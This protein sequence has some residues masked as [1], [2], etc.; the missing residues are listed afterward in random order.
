MTPVPLWALLAAVIAWLASTGG[1][2]FYGRSD[3]RAIEAGTQ[4]RE[5][6]VA[7]VAT[8]AAVLASA[9]AIAAIEVKNVTVKQ[10]V[11]TEIREKPVYRE[12]VH[13]QRVLDDINRSLTGAEP[14]GDRELPAAGPAD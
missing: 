6:K 12:C 2:Y 4:A 14:A 3:G 9:K 11:E 10:R 5:N 13:D 7:E 1:A 8:Q